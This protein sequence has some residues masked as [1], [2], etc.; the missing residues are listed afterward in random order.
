MRKKIISMVGVAALAVS[1]M[2]CSSP[3]GGDT[4][5]GGANGLERLQ[6]SGTIRAGFIT[7]RPL[8]YLD[9]ATGLL[10]G[11]GPAVLRTVMA[12][13]G[14]DNVDGV[15]TDFDAI[16]PGLTA[17][18]WDIS[19]WPF[20]VTPVRCENVAFTNPTAQYLEG[21]M[22]QAGNPLGIESYEDLARPEV[23][24][25]IGSGNAEIEWAKDNGATD[26]QISLFT[27]EA[28]ALE[29]LRNGQVDVYLNAQFGMVQALRNY[30]PTGLEI[31]DPFTG[32]I[33]DGAE[34]VAYGAWAV[35]IDDT[36]LREAFNAELK[37]L[38]ESGELLKLQEP[39]GYDADSIPDPSVTSASLCP[40]ATW[41][42]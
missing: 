21:A 37:K 6:E 18:R 39:F 13:L 42:K 31:A 40:D 17:D 25:A 11:S 30:D 32:P 41:A 4:G 10:D 27:D 38:N 20:Y 22:V 15:L 26:A 1:L 7:N 34:V 35:R 16:I 3:T 2:A 23:R 14:V 19:A 24:I 12:N 29:A 36:E 8:S 28:L 33:I 5:T 9:E